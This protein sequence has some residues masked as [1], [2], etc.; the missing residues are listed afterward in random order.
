VVYRDVDHTRGVFGVS[1][2][3]DFEGFDKRVGGI[4]VLGEVFGLDGCGP[5]EC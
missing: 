5:L 3:V 2:A 4:I 1:L